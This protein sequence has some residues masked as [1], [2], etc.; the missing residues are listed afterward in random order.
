MSIFIPCTKFYLG[1]AESRVPVYKTLSNS[2]L[3][4][5][6]LLYLLFFSFLR[7]GSLSL[8]NIDT[9]FRA[10]TSGLGDF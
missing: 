8:Y 10:H 3:I 7:D 1:L 4:Y 9:P 5:T 2:L 6:M